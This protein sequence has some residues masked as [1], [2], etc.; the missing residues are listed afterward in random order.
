MSKK[1]ATKEAT[2]APAVSPQAPDMALN[3]LS[4][5]V[6]KEAEPCRPTAQERRAKLIAAHVAIEAVRYDVDW[7]AREGIQKAIA[8]A[9]G[10]LELRG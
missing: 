7:S 4:G 1:R 10:E 5:C 8:A 2:E 6:A 3:Q 9:I